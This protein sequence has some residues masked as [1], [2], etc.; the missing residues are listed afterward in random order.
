MRKVLN[1]TIFALIG[2]LVMVSVTSCEKKYSRLEYGFSRSYPITTEAGS[3]E[4]IAELEAICLKYLNGSE[5]GKNLKFANMSEKE[6]EAI[7][8]AYFDAMVA[9]MDKV[10]L[11]FTDGDHYSVAIQNITTDHTRIIK[12]KRYSND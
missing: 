3:L 6:A 4:T 8:V 10:E 2:L 11:K 5:A 1:F 9:E 12:E 7:A